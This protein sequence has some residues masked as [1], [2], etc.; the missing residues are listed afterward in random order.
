[1]ASERSI[2]IEAYRRILKSAKRGTG[3]RLTAQ[4]CFQ[5]SFDQAMEQAVATDD[6]ARESEAS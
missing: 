3:T 6:E 2:L 4:E 1:M 5:M